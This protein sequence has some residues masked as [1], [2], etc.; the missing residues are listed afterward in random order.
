MGYIINRVVYHL[1]ASCY[2][3]YDL[4]F[5][6]FCF[7]GAYYKMVTLCVTSHFSCFYLRKKIS[8]QY[9]LKRYYIIRGIITLDK[10]TYL[11]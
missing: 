10:H 6:L 5:S 3:K 9:M 8:V 1:F 11:T 2:V 7:L 4:V